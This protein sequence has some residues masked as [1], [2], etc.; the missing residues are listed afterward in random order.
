MILQQS[1]DRCHAILLVHR[2]VFPPFF[3]LVGTLDVPH[4]YTMLPPWNQLSA[5]SI[6]LSFDQVVVI[7]ITDGV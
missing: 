5:S 3:K 6:R 7:A 2:N 4:G 1:Y